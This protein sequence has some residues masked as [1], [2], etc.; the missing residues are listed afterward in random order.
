MSIY[1]GTAEIALLKLGTADVSRV[2]LGNAEAWSAVD[3]DAADYFAR[4]VSAGSSISVDNKAAVD[5][6]V[7]GCKADG[8][9]SAIKASCLLAGPDDLTGA[10]VPLVGAAPTNVGPFVSGDHNRTTGLIGNG[11]SKRLNSNRAGN[12]DGQN[13]CHH[14]V[15]IQAAGGASNACLGDES[16]MGGNPSHM[17]PEFAR[18]R[19]NAGFFHSAGVSSTTGFV[20]MRRNNSSNFQFRSAGVQDDCA[21]TSTGTNSQNIMIFSRELA[22]YSSARMSFYSLGSSLDLALLEARLATYMSSLT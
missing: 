10:L 15:W 7:R 14:A 21:T 16:S 18:N 22:N 9:W 2:M 12:V 19:S 5:A 20:G 1:L 11:S 3:P 8:I 17:F 6:F 13:D 4:I